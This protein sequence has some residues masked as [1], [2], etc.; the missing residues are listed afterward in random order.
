MGKIKKFVTKE[1]TIKE[2]QRLTYLIIVK[3]EIKI[4]IK[5]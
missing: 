1:K 4:S 2:R 3:L 5:N